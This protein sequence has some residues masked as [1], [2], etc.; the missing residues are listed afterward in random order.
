MNMDNKRVLKKIAPSLMSIKETIVS[1]KNDEESSFNNLPSSI[2][3]GKMGHRMA[4]NIFEMDIMLDAI[5]D[6]VS[7]LDE[8]TGGAHVK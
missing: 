6:I 3:D 4:K 1:V 2:M 5:E 8:I 7:A